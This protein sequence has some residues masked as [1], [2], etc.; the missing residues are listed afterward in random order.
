MKLLYILTCVLLL[1]CS[2]LFAQLGGDIVHVHDPCIIKHGIPTLQ[3]RPLTW[4][5]D[6]WP[7]AGEPL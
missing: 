6:G 2:S 4:T 7:L 5:K 3:V 1:I